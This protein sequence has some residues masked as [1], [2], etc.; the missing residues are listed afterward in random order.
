M[1][2]AL[3]ERLWKAEAERLAAQ[4]ALRAELRGM[5]RLEFEALEQSDPELATWIRSLP[6]SMLP[7]QL[8]RT[9]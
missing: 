7:A 5:K 3:L 4:A 1:A 8:R 2:H 9:R 6:A